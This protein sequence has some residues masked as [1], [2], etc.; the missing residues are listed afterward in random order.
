[1]HRTP[2][3]LKFTIL[4]AL[5][6]LLAACGGQNGEETAA[7]SQPAQLVFYDWPEDAI[8][9]VFDDFTAETGIEIVY[10]AYESQEEAIANLEAGELYDVVVMENQ[11]VPGLISGGLIAE[12][13]YT[14]VPN[15]R[16][17]TPS[18]RDLKHDPGSRHTIHT[19]GARQ[20]WSFAPTWWKSR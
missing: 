15:A 17:I 2:Q 13:D 5:P 4:L 10:L 9:N 20:A 14:N 11:Y 19:A 8:A 3:L 7:A 12:I 16:N 6:L 1:M 18:F